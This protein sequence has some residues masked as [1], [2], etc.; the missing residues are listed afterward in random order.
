MTFRTLAGI[1]FGV[2]M[3]LILAGCAGEDRLTLD[4]ARAM[5]DGVMRAIADEVPG[6]VVE[7]VSADSPY[8][9]CGNG[10]TYSARWAVTPDEAFRGEDF[11]R[12]LPG[13]LGEDFVIDEEVVDVSYPAVALNHASGIILDVIIADVDGR[14]VVDVYAIAPCASGELPE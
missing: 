14:E 5:T 8:L 3:G 7:D 6:G 9:R 10:Y 13:R 2:L 1:V 11:V 4:D 12:D